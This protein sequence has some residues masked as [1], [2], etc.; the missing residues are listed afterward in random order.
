M[1]KMA[2]WYGHWLLAAVGAFTCVGG[3]YAVIDQIIQAYANGMIGQAFSCADNS[4]IL[5]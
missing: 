4:K 5:A 2:M 1:L 3:T